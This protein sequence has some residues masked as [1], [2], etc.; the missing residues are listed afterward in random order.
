MKIIDIL[1]NIAN[2]KVVPKKIKYDDTIY[3]YDPID[4]DYYG[5]GYNS[6]GDPSDHCSI[7]EEL[8]HLQT[9]YALNLEVEVLK[10]DPIKELEYDSSKKK[11]SP[12]SLPYIMTYLYAHEQKI[13]ELVK[14]VNKLKK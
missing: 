11:D 2:K 9:N 6:E 14:E 8:K 3:T 4:Q 10:D 12:G 5:T 13:N 7:F 1:V